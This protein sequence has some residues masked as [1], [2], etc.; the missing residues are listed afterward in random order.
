MKIAVVID[1]WFPAVGG[2]QINTWEI[3]KRLASKNL[4]IIKLGEKNEP[5]DSLSKIIFA[6]KII[7]FLLRKEYDLYHV[8]PFLPA[9]FVKM[10]GFLKK[11][12]V[13]FTVHGTR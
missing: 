3:T 13:V 12:P 7:P 9:P 10:A 8:H 5:D 4:K 6:F 1:T 2:G 11:T